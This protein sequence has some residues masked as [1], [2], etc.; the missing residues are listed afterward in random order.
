MIE[1]YLQVLEESLQKKMSI[2]LRIEEMNEK[3]EEIL[4]SNEISAEDFDSSI[5]AKGMLIEELSKLDEGFEALYEHIKEQLLNEREKY[6]KQIAKL[7]S[8]IT[9][10]TDKS[11]SIQAQEARNKILAERYFAKA[12]R[13][14]KQ[15]RVSS[16]AALDYYK[17][18][19]RSQVTQPQFMDKKK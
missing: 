10:I 4:T 3:Q 9:E 5:E 15:S 1:N 17:S 8:L 11:V 19:N 18:M 13:D 16:K 14:L 12:K 2:L 7:Q 6:K